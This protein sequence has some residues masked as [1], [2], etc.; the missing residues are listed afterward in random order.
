MLCQFINAEYVDPALIYIRGM[1]AELGIVK[2][3][4]FAPDAKAR[5]LRDQAARAATRTTRVTAH[6]PAPLLKNGGLWY[7]GE[8]GIKFPR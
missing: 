3:E 4:P 5:A 8:R 1:A 6:T 7:P 2:D